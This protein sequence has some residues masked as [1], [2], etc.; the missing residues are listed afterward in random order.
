MAKPK[1]KVTLRHNPNKPETSSPANPATSERPAAPKAGIFAGLR[2]AQQNA[3]KEIKALEKKLERFQSQLRHFKKSSEKILGDK[4]PE[5]LED[6][7]KALEEKF[8]RLERSSRNDITITRL[9]DIYGRLP[10]TNGIDEGGMKRFM[11]NLEGTIR[12]VGKDLIPLNE[13][14]FDDNFAPS[15]ELQKHLARIT[16]SKVYSLEKIQ[17]AVRLTP[18][19]TEYDEDMVTTGVLTSIVLEWVMEDSFPIS[20]WEEGWKYLMDEKIKPEVKSW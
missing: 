3:D 7:P 17:Y 9:F 11:L 20:E 13:V 10:P 14:I 12:N 6:Y 2:S 1:P 16:L 18:R 15:L 19:Q 8:Q 5:N 4:S